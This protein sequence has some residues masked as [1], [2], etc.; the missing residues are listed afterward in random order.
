M[1]SR[2]HPLEVHEMLVPTSGACKQPVGSPWAHLLDPRK[3]PLIQ[4]LLQ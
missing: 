2:L 4:L 1:Q 3:N